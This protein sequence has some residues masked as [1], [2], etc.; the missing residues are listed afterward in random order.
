[1]FFVI[2]LV[3]NYKMVS[4][5]IVSMIDLSHAVYQATRTDFVHFD[6]RTNFK[7]VCVWGR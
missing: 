5:K 4:V 2:F 1:M 3:D 7:R 6:V